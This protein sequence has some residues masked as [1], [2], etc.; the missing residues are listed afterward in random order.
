MEFASPGR[1]NLNIQCDA[2]VIADGEEHV[3]FALPRPDGRIAAGVTFEK[4]TADNVP[5]AEG[6]TSI[7]RNLA[8]VL[9]R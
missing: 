5:T 9:P 4:G 7:L 8:L 1:G 6:R 2:L 3:V